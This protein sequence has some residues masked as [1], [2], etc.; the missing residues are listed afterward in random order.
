[1]AQLISN[2]RLLIEHKVFQL[3][4]EVEFSMSAE[5]SVA[6]PVRLAGLDSKRG[7]CLSLCKAT[8]PLSLSL[9]LSLCVCVQDTPLLQGAPP[10][11]PRISPAPLSSLS[12][13]PKPQNLN[14][15]A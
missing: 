14:P 5:S 6:K 1:M 2:V 4:C 7:S 8:L 15:E 12:G 13:E 11:P 3:F 10:A 9:S